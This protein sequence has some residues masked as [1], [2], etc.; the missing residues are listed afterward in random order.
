MKEQFQQEDVVFD[1]SKTNLLKLDMP[2]GRKRY[3]IISFIIGAIMLVLGVLVKYIELANLL[4][5]AV[6]IV[7][8]LILSVLM[9]LTVI[10]DSKR[11]WD[12]CEQ[13]R[14]GLLFAIILFL[15]NIVLF[16][17]GLKFLSFIVYMCMILVR[18]KLVK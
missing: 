5:P 4:L 8:F 9:F 1:D 10:N 15:L 17:T 11:F 16:F 14:K 3:F 6:F 2:I 18:G 12:L 13:K 7:V